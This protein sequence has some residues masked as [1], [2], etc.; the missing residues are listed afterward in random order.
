MIQTLKHRLSTIELHIRD[1]IQA[2]QQKAEI[3][4]FSVIK[5]KPKYFYSYAKRF[6]KTKSCR[7]PLKQTNGDYVNCPSQMANLI[8]EQLSLECLAIHSPQPK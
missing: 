3:K 5:T 1:N 4:A 8:Q 7:G 6:A 2:N